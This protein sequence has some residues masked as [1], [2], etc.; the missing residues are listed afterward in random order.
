MGELY[1]NSLRKNIDI[2]LRV[3][4]PLNHGEG[5]VMRILDKQKSTMPLPAWS[6]ADENLEKYRDVIK[7]PYGMIL[8]CGPTGSGKS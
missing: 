5:V 7:Q 6:F 4:A 3:A 8:H 1:S 2:D